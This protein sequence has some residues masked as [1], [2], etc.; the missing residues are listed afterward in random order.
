MGAI[1]GAKIRFLGRKFENFDFSECFQPL[2]CYI[3]LERKYLTEYESDKQNRHRSKGQHLGLR[4]CRTILGAEIRL[5]SRKFEN[6]DFWKGFQPLTCYTSLEM[7]SLT[8]YKS[9]KQNRNRSRG[10]PLS[11]REV[12]SILGDG[13]RFL[14]RKFE[15]IDFWEWFRPLTCYISFAIVVFSSVTHGD[16]YRCID[17]SCLGG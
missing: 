14:V 15:N 12:G 13:I 3:S 16:T 1:L 8:E 10:Q 4:K 2:T 5:L 11:L 6:I 7:K 17:M 9:D